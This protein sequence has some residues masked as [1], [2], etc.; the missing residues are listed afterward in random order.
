MRKEE[1][2]LGAEVVVRYG[3]RMSRRAA[4]VVVG[5]VRGSDGRPTAYSVAGHGLAFPVTV[6]ADSVELA[7]SLPPFDPDWVEEG[8]FEKE[9][10]RRT[11]R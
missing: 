2:E 4:G 5:V 1:I 6:P 7:S 8:A 3:P 11:R 10:R 9:L